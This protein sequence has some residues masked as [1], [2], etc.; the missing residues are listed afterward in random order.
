MHIHFRLLFRRASEP[1]SSDRTAKQQIAYAQNS[2]IIQEIWNKI[3]VQFSS[4]RN[5]NQVQN[6]CTEI[7]TEISGLAKEIEDFQRESDRSP[8]LHEKREA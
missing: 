3:K 5:K 2:S 4:I 7:S 8:F 1:S 6:A